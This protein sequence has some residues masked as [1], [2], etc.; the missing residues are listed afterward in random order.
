MAGITRVHLAVLVL[1]AFCFRAESFA[2]AAEQKA[3]LQGATYVN[4]R[5]GPGLNHPP[6]AVLKE[7]D[8]VVV[9]GQAE[10]WYLVTTPDG[11][12]G[13]VH[14][15]FLQIAEEKQAASSAQIDTKSAVGESKEPIKAE[16]P[17]A[18]TAPVE[19]LPA[20]A[21]TQNAATGPSSVTS[22]ATK[23]SPSVQRPTDQKVAS[24]KSPSVIQ[25]LEGRET[26]MMLW[27]AI[28]IVFFLIGWICGGKYYL[29][30]DRVRRT[31]LR[32]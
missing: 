23:P 2:L 13:Y 27:A 17:T 25:L 10:E 1:W 31:K 32:F 14:R 24:A 18:S 21:V 19:S 26:D 9:D 29:R 12:K 8:T 7:G 3:T 16:T 4:L 22:P 30:R 15:M 5:G 6:K 28:A 20:P 11:Q